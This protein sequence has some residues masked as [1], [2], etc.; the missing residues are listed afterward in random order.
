MPAAG[1]SR[2]FAGSRYIVSQTVR[3]LW[4][5]HIRNVLP[6]LGQLCCLGGLLPG[7]AGPPGIL[8]KG[9]STWCAAMTRHRENPDSTRIKKDGLVKFIQRKPIRSGETLLFFI[10]NA[11]ITHELL[12]KRFFRL[13]AN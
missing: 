12:G 1:R 6:V 11:H 4:L 10:M 5:Y 8:V 7:R 3:L 9:G 2:R 13:D